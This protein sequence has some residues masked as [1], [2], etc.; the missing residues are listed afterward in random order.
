MKK[1]TVRFDV[2]PQTFRLLLRLVDTGLWGETADEVALQCMYRGLQEAHRGDT[3]KPATPKFMRPASGGQQRAALVSETSAFIWCDQCDRR[4]SLANAKAC[5]A[6][7]CTAV[8]EA[9]AKD[10]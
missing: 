9:D 3:L 1:E 4:V 10:G 6:P 5:K 2:S 7:F 8:G